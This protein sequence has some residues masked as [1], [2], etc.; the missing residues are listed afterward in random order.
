MK[1][2][3]SLITALILVP[4]FSFAMITNVQDDNVKQARDVPSFSSISLSI[5][6]DVHLKQGAKQEVIV[7]GDKDVLDVLKTE[8]QGKTLKIY[9]DKWFMSSYKKVT[10]YITVPEIDGLKITGSGNITAET[11]VN[12]SDIDFTI[13]GSGDIDISELK[14]DQ[15]KASI[16]GSGTINLAG[17]QTAASMDVHISGSGDVN[18]DK[19]EVKNFDASITG[20]GDCRITATEVLKARVSGSGDIYY[21]GKPRMDV[22]IT[23]S[24]KLRSL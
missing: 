7:E 3:K 16:T 10:I 14:A 8:V 1:Y 20:S 2:M 18:A 6:A 23:G 12:T 19:L 9:L 5:A 22:N 15:I 24:G 17:K 13:T 11:P 4:L 21:K